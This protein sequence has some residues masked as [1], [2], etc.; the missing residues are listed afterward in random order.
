MGKTRNKI[1]NEINAE[2]EY[3]EDKWGDEFDKNNGFAPRHYDKN[4]E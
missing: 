1:V 2:R 4:R 3:Q